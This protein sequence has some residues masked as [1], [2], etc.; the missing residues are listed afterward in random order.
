MWIFHN[1]GLPTSQGANRHWSLLMR[2]VGINRAHGGQ[3]HR[4]GGFC[5][6]VLTKDGDP[7]KNNPIENIT[8]LVL[9]IGGKTT[10]S[11][12]VDAGG[13]IDISSMTSESTGIIKVMGNFENALRANNAAFFKQTDKIDQRRL[14]KAF[15]EGKYIG[16][17]QVIP[18]DKEAEESANLLM[19]DI[20]NILARAGGLASYDGV[21]LTGGGAVLMSSRLQAQYAPIPFYLAEN[22]M[23]MAHFANVRGGVKL[24]KMLKRLGVL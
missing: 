17:G 8:V 18:C 14:N 5:H 16:G 23:D 6:Y 12:A 11:V 15:I 24:F 7:R 20:E 21:L 19:N 13:N 2:S 3:C 10:D 4:A 22:D 9:D 1:R